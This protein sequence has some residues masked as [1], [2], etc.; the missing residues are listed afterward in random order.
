MKV[1]NDMMT[2]VKGFAKQYNAKRR[3]TQMI[4]N[5]TVGRTIAM[6]RQARG[7]TQQQL[8][9]AMN[10]SH[11]A[12]SKWENGA[13]L[14]DIQTLVGLTQL[15]GITVEQLL[16]GE[17]PEER[18][19]DEQE[20]SI[21]DRIH[22]IG[23]IVNNVIDDIGSAL[24]GE[25]HRPEE[26]E[27]ADSEP[28]RT[29]VDIKELLEMAPF[30]SKAAVAEM[31][32]KCGRRLSAAEIARF[33]PF[34]DA[35]CLE[36]LIRESEGEFTWDSLRKLAPFLRKEAVDAFARAIALG[37]KFVKPVSDDVGRAAGDAWKAVE[38][39]SRK[40]EM[41]V[42]K[43]V[44][45]V[46]RMGENMV[47]EVAKAFDDLASESTAR[48]ERRAQLRHSAIERALEDGKWDWIAAHIDEVQDEELRRR[49]S[50]K[51]NREG[52]QEWVYEHLGGYVD[53]T[54]INQAIEEGNW[55]WLGE[56][57]E[58]F[59][60]AVRRLI[61]CAAAENAQWDWLC[62]RAEQI[63][64]GE[65]AGEIASAARRDGAKLLAAQ[66]VRYDMEESQ[67]KSLVMEAVADGDYEF[68]EMVRD[69]LSFET[70]CDCC[71]AFAKDDQWA[72]V[73]QFSGRLDLQGME[74]LM[75]LAIEM[76]DFDAVDMMDEMIRK[77]EDEV[78]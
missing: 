25:E 76:G 41:G 5:R 2:A 77:A 70:V 78:R 29:N 48:E 61:A 63:Q 74:R 60:P 10:V 75:E 67:I 27:N 19:E 17:I 6:L 21:D 7:M 59:E 62:A 23:K 15:F 31:L 30:M 73:E 54:V 24:R 13:A 9:A 68:V 44:R 28:V 34:V 56:H 65:A 46:V 47:S 1:E 69:I 52:M 11:Q 8:A 26:T 45:K 4:D 3:L 16:N 40:I 51:A 53:P 55:E 32:E 22:S 36:K 38:D 49:I 43:A 72:R 33:A 50:E 58:E 71:M 14:P 35:A 57:V 18:L 42:D 66:L 20:L 64:L 12:V 39:V 37:E